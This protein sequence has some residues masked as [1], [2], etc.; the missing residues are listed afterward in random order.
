MTVIPSG[1]RAFVVIDPEA[2]ASNNNET[3]ERDGDSA[4]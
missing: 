4:P 1:H 2:V 3:S